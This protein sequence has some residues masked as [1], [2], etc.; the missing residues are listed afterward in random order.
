MGQSREGAIWTL[1][2]GLNRGAVW[3]HRDDHVGA[4]GR[5]RRSRRF[6]PAQFDDPLQPLLRSV[7]HS[8]VEARRD[9][10]GRHGSP[11]LTYAQKSDGYIVGVLTVPPCSP[12]RTSDC[13]SLGLARYD[14]MPPLAHS[15][16]IEFNVF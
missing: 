6:N 5:H 11:H 3:Q 10:A 9:Q 14:L 16:A 13:G 4:S 8:D 1:H 7:P 12:F 2:N 15:A